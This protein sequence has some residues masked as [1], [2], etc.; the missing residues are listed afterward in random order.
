MFG[1]I[2]ETFLLEIQFC[3]E[4]IFPH[5]LREIPNSLKCNVKWIVPLL[6]LR[7]A[8]ITALGWNWQF[9]NLVLKWLFYIIST[10]DH[11]EQVVTLKV[12]IAAKAIW[13]FK[14]GTSYLFPL[15]PWLKCFANF[16]SNSQF[17]D[18]SNSKFSIVSVF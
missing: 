11:V 1:I 3:V 2:P 16:P 7:Y 10:S 4:I 13:P 9:F 18:T 8:N 5:S 12:E 14:W 6:Q 17:R 15:R